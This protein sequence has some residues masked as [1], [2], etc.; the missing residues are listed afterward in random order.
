M[1]ISAPRFNYK[2][3]PVGDHPSQVEITLVPQR[4]VTG[5]VVDVD[6][7]KPVA[8]KTF[9]LCWFNRRAD[10]TIDRGN[11]RPVPFEQAKPGEFRVAYRA[12]QNLHLTVRRPATMTRKPIS[13][14]A[15][16]TKT[17]PAW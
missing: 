15:R 7:G 14:N 3:V 11:C 1:E 12:P 9:I 16:T 2:R 5:R 8:V 6:S 4:W 10:G 13:T 17:S